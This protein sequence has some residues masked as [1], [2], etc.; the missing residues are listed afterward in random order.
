MPHKIGC[1]PVLKKFPSPLNFHNNNNTI[2]AEVCHKGGSIKTNPAYEMESYVLD[3]NSL[4]MEYSI[5]F[6]LKKTFGIIFLWISCPLLEV[7]A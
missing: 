1:A 6:E 5:T 3:V 2:P 7:F 4:F